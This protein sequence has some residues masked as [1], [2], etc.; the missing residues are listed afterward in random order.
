MNEKIP[1]EL[2]K[3]SLKSIV[4]KLLEENGKMYGYEI[5]QKVDTLTGGKIQLTYG[6]LYPILHKLEKEGNLITE[7]QNVKNRI[8][9]YY[10][11]TP[12]GDSLAKEK[13]EE[14]KDFIETITILLQPKT[15]LQYVPTKS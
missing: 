8:R 1:K 14:L 6:A 3:G 12:K 11:L 2:L 7:S 9:I 15:A 10:Q 13:I 4:L 5:T